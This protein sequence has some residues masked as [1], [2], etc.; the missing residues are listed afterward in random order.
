MSERKISGTL[1]LTCEQWAIM[2]LM[3]RKEIPQ[4]PQILWSSAEMVECAIEKA[5]DDSV[6][7]VLQ[8]DLK[9]IISDGDS[10]AKV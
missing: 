9:N 2:L 6:Q 5:M 1:E 8:E 4:L 3:I 7:D 10:D